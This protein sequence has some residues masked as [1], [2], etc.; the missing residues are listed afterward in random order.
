MNDREFST[1]AIKSVLRNFL[2]GPVMPL[3]KDEN[4]GDDDSFMDK[5]IL[6]STGVLELVGFLEKEFS[7]RV[8]SDELI[9]DNLDS[10]NKL[11]AFIQR[12]KLGDQ[13]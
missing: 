13:N 2:S 3:A 11:I 4:F 1:E 9:P 8:E 10:L 12:K 7:L 5:G 6:D